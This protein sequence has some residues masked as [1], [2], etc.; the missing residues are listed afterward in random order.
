MVTGTGDAPKSMVSFLNACER[1]TD[2]RFQFTPK[3]ILM[4]VESLTS[5]PVLIPEVTY[6][7]RPGRQK[8]GVVKGVV[9]LM[10]SPPPMAPPPPPDEKTIRRLNSLAARRPFCQLH[11]VKKYDM[12]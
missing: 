11:R 12:L 8:P 4:R 7:E 6:G 2:Y 5:F 3:N 10:A 1:D 9:K